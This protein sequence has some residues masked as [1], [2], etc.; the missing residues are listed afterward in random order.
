MNSSIE[1]SGMYVS[2]KHSQN[3]EGNNEPLIWVANDT[4]QGDPGVIYLMNH[5]GDDKGTYYLDIGNECE[6]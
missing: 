1:A 3:V 5:H 4:Q 2:K 6:L